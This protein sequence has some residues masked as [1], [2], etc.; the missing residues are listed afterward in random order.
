M[1]VFED[2]VAKKAHYRK[3]GVRGLDGQDDFAAMAEVVSRRF[4]RLEK[5]V[6]DGLRRLVRG[7]AEP[8]RRSTAARASCRPR[9]R[10]CS[11]STS[12]GW[13]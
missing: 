9:W 3:F 8:R 4:A 6:S 10:R 2:A 5:P 12:S 11:G 7:G 13:P 1:V